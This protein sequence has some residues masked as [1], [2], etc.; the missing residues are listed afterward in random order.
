MAQRYMAFARSSYEEPLAYRGELEA[1][2]PPTAQQLAFD[3]FGI[4]WVELSLVPEAAV[5]WIL[6]S[7]KQPQGEELAR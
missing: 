5:R 1:E 2:D 4:D 3:R 7:D 6:R